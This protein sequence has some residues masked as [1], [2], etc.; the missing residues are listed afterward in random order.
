ML[1][2]LKIAGNSR[3][4]NRWYLVSLF[5]RSDNVSEKNNIVKLEQTYCY[6]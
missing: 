5:Y 3:M 1:D 4:G 2:N 6:V